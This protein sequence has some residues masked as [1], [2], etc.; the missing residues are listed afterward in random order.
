[1]AI[2][3]VLFDLNGTLLP[4]DYDV[5]T[6]RYFGLLA[7]KMASMGYEASGIIDNVLKG[8][9]AMMMAASI[10]RGVAAGWLSDSYIK[11]ADLVRE[12]MDAYVDE[13]GIIHEVCGC[14]M[15]MEVGTSAESMASY[16][17]M[18]AWFAKQN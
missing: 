3:A 4:M 9:A 5:F 15:F 2:K 14:P 7:A 12:N 1:M 8:T 17:M 16:L 10:Y 11:Y 18:H 6:R 13:F